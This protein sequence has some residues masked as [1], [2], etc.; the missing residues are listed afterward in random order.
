MK[1]NQ[2]INPGNVRVLGLLLIAGFCCIAMV[3]PVAAIYPDDKWLTDNRTVLANNSNYATINGV[4]FYN[5]NFFAITGNGHYNTTA[6]AWNWSTDP[7]YSDRYYLEQLKV[8]VPDLDEAYYPSNDTHYGGAW[9]WE[10]LNDLSCSGTIYKKGLGGYVGS[11]SGTYYA[12]YGNKSNAST[13]EPIHNSTRS[14]LTYNNATYV[15][16]LT[17]IWNG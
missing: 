10:F 7:Q 1:P 2:M 13:T 17:E 9:Q 5:Y 4:Q 11:S 8:G 16:N 15:V 6:P 12:W 14:C 3:A